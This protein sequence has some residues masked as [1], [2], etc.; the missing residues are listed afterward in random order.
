MAGARIGVAAVVLGTGAVV[1]ANVASSPSNSPADESADESAA[2]TTVLS[3]VAAT[4]STVLV[5]AGPDPSG[6]SAPTT[7]LVA[8]PVPPVREPT[9]ETAA[10]SHVRS[11]ESVW[12]DDRVDVLHL[13]AEVADLCTAA[14][15]VEENANLVYVYVFENPTTGGTCAA[16]ETGV[17]TADLDGPLG[18]RLVIDAVTGE[19]FVVGLSDPGA[20]AP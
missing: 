17:L 1:H 9:A 6:E 18:A 5:T 3:A 8:A 10:P 2:T 15:K 7:V 19:Q 4:T 11:V 20:T 14:V 12:I 13:R 16:A